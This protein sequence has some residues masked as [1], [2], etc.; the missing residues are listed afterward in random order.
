MSRFKKKSNENKIRKTIFFLIIIFLT[1]TMS[2]IL[3]DMYRN[4]EI[5]DYNAENNATA[6]RTSITL[7]QNSEEENTL[8]II[9]N[10]SKSVVGISKINDIGISIFNINSTKNLELGTGVIVSEN[11]YIITNQHVSGNKYSKCY[12]TL[13]DGKEYTANVVWANNDIDLAVIKINSY[14]L[15]A[16]KIGDSDNIRVGQTVYAIGNPIGLDFQRTVTKGIIS[17]IDRTVK[18]EES[19]T[20]YMEDL[21]QTDATINPGNSGG[22]LINEKGEV[23][24]INSV[25]ITTAEGIGFAI[26]I[27]VVKPVI[28]KM[29]QNGIFEE[30]SIG[31]FAYDSKMAKYIDSKT[32]FENGIYV[33]S[34]TVGGS[35]Y[36]AGV[37]V[38]DIITK[39]DNVEINKMSKLREYIYTKEIGDTVVLTIQRNKREIQIEIKIG[40]I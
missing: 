26:P 11:G 1:S 17:A 35:A 29:K 19:E 20:I 7:A 22:P 32:E 10:S 3:Y 2:I 39:I 21:I 40:R 18:L 14:G 28:E 9:E 30:A 23:V 34:I 24:G 15:D 27:N 13:Y 36:T 38:G 4:I 37:Q 33:A 5:K 12:V 16:I 31:I 8:D 25:K 6:T